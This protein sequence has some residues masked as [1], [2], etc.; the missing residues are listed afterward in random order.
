VSPGSYHDL[1]DEYYDAERHP[2]CANFREGS[3]LLVERWLDGQNE[4]SAPRWDVGAG[5]SVLAEVLAARGI[6]LEGTTALDE[7]PSMLAHSEKWASQG[8]R[9]VV[10]DAEGIPAENGSAAFVLASLGDPY[11][12]DGWWLEVARVLAPEGV[13]LFT[14]PTHE[15]AGGFR[16]GGAPD[17]AE[18]ELADGRK[19]LVP[20]VVRPPEEQV[21]QI[22]R[23]GLRVEAV[24]HV[25]RGEL[26][27]SPLSPKLTVLKGDEAPVVRGYRVV[28]REVGE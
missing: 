7:S 28:K 8:L 19:V 25:T 27:R 4:L 14:T 16:N 21:R 26:R 18:F 15:W 2:T 1:A 22:E 17:V 20:S 13:C 10:G 9:L 23:A 5:D 24:E 3:I 12:T 6:A 11:N